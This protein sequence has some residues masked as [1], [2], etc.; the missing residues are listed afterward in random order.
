MVITRSLLGLGDFEFK[1]MK[2]FSQKFDRNFRKI[3]LTF[4]CQKSS[5]FYWVQLSQNSEIP[6][7]LIYL[8]FFF[9]MEAVLLSWWYKRSPTLTSWVYT[10]PISMRTVQLL[11]PADF[12]LVKISGRA[13]VF[14]LSLHEVGDKRESGK[15]TLKASSSRI[16]LN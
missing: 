8:E 1:K 11:G 16:E 9:R 3:F 2:V 15:S 10:D 4:F 7:I 14:V 5:F 6:K 12:T 13:V